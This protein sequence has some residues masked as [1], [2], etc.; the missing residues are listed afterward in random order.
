MAAVRGGMVGVALLL[1]AGVVQAQPANDDCASATVIGSLPFTDAVDVS[2]ATPEAGDPSGACT[3]GPNVWYVLPAV[4]SDRNVYAEVFGSDDETAS[5]SFFPG[6]CGAFGSELGQCGTGEDNGAAHVPAG[7]TVYVSVNAG[8]GTARVTI[9]EV[10]EFLVTDDGH[11]YSPQGVGGSPDG[12]FIV[13]WDRSS[14]TVA[15]ARVYDGPDSPV[16]GEMSLAASGG[17]N[18]DA[19]GLS[20]SGFV[21]TWGS[22]SVRLL[23]DTGTPTGPAFAVDTG[24]EEPRVAADG[25][26]NF[27]VA[28]QSAGPSFQLFDS[29]GSALGPHVDLPESTDYPIDVGMDA[30]GNF[31]IVWSDYGVDFPAK[32]LAQRFDATGSGLGAPFVVSDT[33]YPPD[34]AFEELAVAMSESGEFVVA[35]ESSDDYFYLE[36]ARARVFDANGVPKGGSF[37]VSTVD[38]G[39]PKHRL[40]ADD[41]GNGDFIVVWEDDGGR[42]GYGGTLEMLGRRVSRTGAAGGPIFQVADANW[43]DQ[44]DPNVAG[45]PNG[46][47]MVVWNSYRA[48]EPWGSNYAVPARIFGPDDARWDSACAAAPMTGC[49]TPVVAAASRLLIRDQ[50]D[51]AKDQLKWKLTKGGATAAEDFGNPAQANLLGV[52]LYDAADALVYD[53]RL[54]PGGN[55]GPKPCWKALGKP[56]GAKGYKYKNKGGAPDGLQ[57]AVLKPGDAGRTKVVVKGGKENLSASPTGFSP[58]PLALPARMQLQG[59]DG[60]CWE[61]VFEPAGV[62]A[63]TASLLRA[64]SAAP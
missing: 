51:D 55:C 14:S 23:D 19:D 62:Q 6:T 27:V 38:P 3:G 58:L 2:L 41:D 63:S 45:G 17:W 47:F 35:W 36:L 9:D 64:K 54:L 18:P 56:A 28:W 61:A 44:Y 52:C 39:Y 29:S 37:P 25:A 53:G 33:E 21:V 34:Y 16:A 24:G 11:Q 1:V 43:H 31:V 15:D 26:G 32:I 59:V 40:R 7:T 8:F 42:T 48:N 49:I 46:E 5:V 22:G 57:K 4:G 50:D 20:P 60:A 10:H 30:A 12:R 13:V